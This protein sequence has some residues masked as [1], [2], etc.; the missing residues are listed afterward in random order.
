MAIVKAECYMEDIGRDICSPFFDQFG[1]L[2]IIFQ[3]SGEIL[4]VKDSNELA[5]VHSTSGQPSGNSPIFNLI[6]HYS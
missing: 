6:L 4:A 3:D 1:C 5:L 2:H